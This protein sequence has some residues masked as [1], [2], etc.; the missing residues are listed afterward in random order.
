MFGKLRNMWM[1]VLAL[2]VVVL[3]VIVVR[4]DFSKGIASPY[5]ERLQ[6][7]GREIVMGDEGDSRVGNFV[8]MPQKA[9][10]QAKAAT[11]EA[12]SLLSKLEDLAGIGDKTIYL[13]FTCISDK[14][15][16]DT[17][18]PDFQQYWKDKRGEQVNFVT[19]FSLLGFDT[20]ATSVDGV[21]A[22]LLIMSSSTDPLTRGFGETKW[23]HTPNQGVVLSYPQVFVVRKG[24]PKGIHTY[25][26]LTIPGIRVVHLNPLLGTGGGLWPVYGI[27][28]SA[29]RE[30]EVTTGY[31]N[32]HTGYDRL[33]KIEFNAYYEAG[34]TPEAVRLFQKGV[35]DVLV[36]SEPAALRA[37]KKDDS[38]E[39]VVPP[40]TVVND[41]RVYRSDRNIRF[42]DREVVDE[43]VDYLFTEEAQKAVASYGF[44]PS[45]PAVL[46]NH[47]EFAPLEYPFTIS[48][49]GDPTTVKKDIILRKWLKINNTRP[50]L[51]PGP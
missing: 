41:L 51:T 42:S 31:K 4:G 25:E 9:G 32:M 33:K 10:G 34:E 2:L 17:L 39:L 38:L 27:Y 45:S 8:H 46:G 29:L 3:T 14:L 12:K 40:Y 26:D 44:R 36:V 50:S 47:P 49:L 23:K 22:Q 15:L 43:F 11:P 1:R 37:V 5:K 28:G 18:L 7:N 19:G 48:Y 16:F 30:S 24:N 6:L 21:P 20:L 13:A 35:G